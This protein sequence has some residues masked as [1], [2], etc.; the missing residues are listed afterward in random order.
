VVYIYPAV[1]GRI[2]ASTVLTLAAFFL[3]GIAVFYIARAYRLRKEGID[4]KWT[5][6]SVPPI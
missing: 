2:G 1:G 5:F 4:I 3:S 6:S